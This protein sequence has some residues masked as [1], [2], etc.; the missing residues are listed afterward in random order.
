MTSRPMKL[1]SWSIVS[2][3]LLA[4]WSGPDY[5]LRK[6]IA[7]GRMDSRGVRTKVGDSAEDHDSRLSEG[8]TDWSKMMT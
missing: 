1:G 5:A 4:N 7:S 6:I 8:R 2:Q 3:G